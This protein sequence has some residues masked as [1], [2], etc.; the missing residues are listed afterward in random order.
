CYDEELTQKVGRPAQK[1]REPLQVVNAGAVGCGERWPV[2]SAGID[3][4]ACAANR[5]VELLF[6]DPGEAP[7]LACHA[8]GGCDAAACDLY[9]QQ[10]YR[11]VPLPA[12]GGGG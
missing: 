3:G 9:G 11:A 5:R 12:N 6:F 8:G 7:R 1:A 2:E 4:L 10:R